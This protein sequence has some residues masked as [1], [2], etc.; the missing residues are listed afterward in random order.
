MENNWTVEIR[1]KRKVKILLYPTRRRCVQV[2]A[3]G[4]GG[5]QAE[6]VPK[7]VTPR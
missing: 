4:G 6:P 5:V 3:W 2:L 1:W 7:A